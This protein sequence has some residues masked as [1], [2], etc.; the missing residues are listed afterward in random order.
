MPCYA[1]VASSKKAF[2]LSLATIAINEVDPRIPFGSTAC[3]DPFRISDYN[4]PIISTCIIYLP[5]ECGASQNSHQNQELVGLE[6]LL[7]PDP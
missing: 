4:T 1:A 2:K 6:D 3:L 5:D 7:G